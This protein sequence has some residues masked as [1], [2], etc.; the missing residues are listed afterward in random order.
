MLEYEFVDKSSELYGGTYKGAWYKGYPD[1]RWVPG[2]TFLCEVLS[3]VVCDLR[4]VW[5]VLTACK[6]CYCCSCVGWLTTLLVWICT[7]TYTRL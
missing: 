7:G 3:A 5:I 1:G 2:T 4:R 6:L